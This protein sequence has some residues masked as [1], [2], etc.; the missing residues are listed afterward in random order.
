[1]TIDPIDDCTFW[2]TSEYLKANGTLQLEHAHR[3]LQVP[4]L[5]LAAAIEKFSGAGHGP[6]SIRFYGS[7]LRQRE[8]LDQE[9]TTDPT[10]ED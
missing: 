4:E 1:M 8:R 10:S 6:G 5:Q 3:V 9:P 7:D 2:Y